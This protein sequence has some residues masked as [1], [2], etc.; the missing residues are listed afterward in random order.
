MKKLTKKIT[1]TNL[2]LACNYLEKQFDTRSW[3]P[4]AQPGLA[5]QE[6]KLMHDSP[7]ALNVWCE[8]WL[9]PS[10]LRKLERKIQRTA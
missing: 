5:K 1:D 10:Q 3:W 6:F 7:G 9:D 8:R 4:R 2:Q